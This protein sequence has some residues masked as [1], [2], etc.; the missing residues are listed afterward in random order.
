MPVVFETGQLKGKDGSSQNSVA[1]LLKDG[2]A[3]RF[4]DE[5]YECL[6]IFKGVGYEKTA[7]KLTRSGGYRSFNSVFVYS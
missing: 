6:W 1:E 5:H 4:Y 2:N 7:I 3:I